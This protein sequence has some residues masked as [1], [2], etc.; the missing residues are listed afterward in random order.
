MPSAIFHQPSE[1]PTSTLATLT[2]RL[3][4]DPLS[5]SHG[6]DLDHLEEAEAAALRLLLHTLRITDAELMESREAQLRVLAELSRLLTQQT[7]TPAKK[8][9][10]VGRLGNRGLLR[11]ADY[12]V[13]FADDWKIFE[14]R[15]NERRASIKDVFGELT[16]YR[17][18]MPDNRGVS[19]DFPAVTLLARKVSPQRGRPFAMLVVAER[20]ASVLRVHSSWRIPLAFIPPSAEPLNML[21]RFVDE[22]GVMLTIPGRPARKL[23][24]YDTVAISG[25]SAEG[26]PLPLHPQ[27]DEP[28]IRTS[29][30]RFSNYGHTLEVAIAFAIDLRRYEDLLKLL[31]S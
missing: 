25:P 18:L 6:P 23:V 10:A 17:H 20:L 28:V 16:A 31:K 11:L 14:T 9:G 15:F 30:F 12:A 21:E 29:V 5:S 4:I 27:G 22:F 1:I 24:I 13:E 3:L 2:N 26:F 19:L 8:Q 7:L